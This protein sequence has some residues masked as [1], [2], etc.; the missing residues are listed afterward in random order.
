[1]PPGLPSQPVIFQ[2]VDDSLP[3]GWGGIYINGGEANLAA[4]TIRNAGRGQGYPYPGPH[5]SLWV[6]EGGHLAVN[7]CSFLIIAASVN[8]M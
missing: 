1:M 7:T 8:R 4:A 6:D 3:T 5:P 2:A